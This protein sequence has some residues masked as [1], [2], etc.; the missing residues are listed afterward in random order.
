[1][2]LI[3]VSL[4]SITLSLLLVTLTEA[5]IYKWEDAKGQVHYASVPPNSSKKTSGL[6]KDFLFIK[7]HRKPI[8]ET[9]PNNLENKNKNKNNKTSSTSKIPKAKRSLCNKKQK[10][11]KM[12]LDNPIVTWIEEGK[13]I[14][15]S[16]QL[17]EDKIEALQEDLAESCGIHN[18]KKQ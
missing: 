9:K 15:L 1:M 6:T 17:L 11:L 2:K 8:K 5:K 14:Q 13:E 3:T 18:K 12:L 10:N 4:F 16:G 7:D